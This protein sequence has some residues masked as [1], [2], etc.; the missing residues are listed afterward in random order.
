MNLKYTKMAAMLC[1]LLLTA[2]SS[3]QAVV[4]WDQSTIDY[5]APVSVAN[6]KASGFGGGTNHSVDDVTVTGSPWHV[7][8]ITEY[9]ATFNQAW[10]SMTQGYLHVWSKTGPMPTNNPTLDTL[11]PMTYVIT[12]DP[13]GVATVTASGLNLTL[14]PG[15]YWI[16]I[17]P[18]A[19]AGLNGV[20]NQWPALGQIGS[21]VATYDTSWHNFYGNYDGAMKVEGDLPT[22]T[23][24]TTW[25]QIKALYH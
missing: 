5:A 16:G 21:P 11:V 12:S 2:A 4:L 15:D 17:T 13:N 6:W 9:Y 18:I 20:N 23:V 10:T 1:G 14:P 8:S 24:N 3:A 7:T 19:T 22:P 25:G